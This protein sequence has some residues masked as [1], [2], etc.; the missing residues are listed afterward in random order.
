MPITA[1]NAVLFN[2]DLEARVLES[3]GSPIPSVNDFE[4]FE[5][6][7]DGLKSSSP[8]IYTDVVTAIE[9]KMDNAIKPPMS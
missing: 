9:R 3:T 6:W 5:A 8:D 4:T 1:E 7:L 2:E